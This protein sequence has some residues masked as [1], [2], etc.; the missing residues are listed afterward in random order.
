MLRRTPV[1]DSSPRKVVGVDGTVCEISPGDPWPLP[2]RGSR[3]TIKEEEG[4]VTGVWH[5]QDLSLTTSNVP[6]RLH[7]LMVKA[8]KQSGSLCV[9]AHRAVITKVPDGNGAWTPIYLGEYQ[10]DFVFPKVNNDPH[11]LEPGSHWTGLPFHHGDKWSISPRDRTGQLLWK[12]SG[13]YFGSIQRFPNLWKR[14]VSIRFLGGIVYFNE[15]GH[16]WM[17]LP[18]DQVG[19]D[20][21]EP[22]RRLQAA[23]VDALAKRGDGAILSLIAARIEATKCRPV[24]LGRIS[25]FDD[26]TAPWTQFNSLGAR[27]FGKGSEAVVD[28]AD[29]NI[30]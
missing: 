14:Y 19:D 4:K 16:V 24:Y 27:T 5:W 13:F 17:N 9:T 20:Y 22:F 15:H 28:G 11:G 29:F 3:Y 18:D 7:Q 21:I 2:Y 23:Q 12:H 26:G 10:N 8:G 1:S 25:D 6:T 30:T